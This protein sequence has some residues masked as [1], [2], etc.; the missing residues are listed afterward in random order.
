MVDSTRTRALVLAGGGA[1]GAYEVGV[2]HYIF[3]ELART[4]PV[5]PRFDIFAGTS[6]GAINGCFLAA[7]AH[8]DDYF[9][10]RLVEL[11]TELRVKRWLS[12]H[13]RELVQVARS[14]MGLGT[15]QWGRRRRPLSGGRLG[16]LLNTQALDDIVIK[17]LCDNRISENIA[18]GYLRAVTVSTTE[19]ATG[20]TVCFVEKEGELPE[21]SLDSRRIARKADLG[22]DH[23]LASA[24]IPF[25]FPAVS[26]DGS[27][28]CDGGVRQP[29]PLSPALRLGADRVLVVALRHRSPEVTQ[30]QLANLGAYPDALFLFGKLLNALLL[31]PVEY[32]LAVLERVNRIMRHGR[33]VYGPNF[34]QELNAVVEPTRGK[35]YR[36]IDDILIKPR[37]DI[38]RMA[39]AAGSRMSRSDWGFGPAAQ[40]LRRFVRAERGAEADLLSYILF[41]GKFTRQL[42]QLGYEDAKAQRDQ[43]VAFFSDEPF[44]D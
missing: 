3:G 19:I 31:D 28:Y 30:E 42:I 23:A 21:W 18:E 38:G 10:D 24:A 5:V 14:V 13:Y 9:I 34:E 17:E 35:P 29:T 36:I 11:W 15:V 2:L 43:L 27:F 16:G 32:D 39:H 1:R 8:H 20:R 22:P 4:G 41:E 6:V 12:I 7:H 40:V 37:A 25:L 44:P 26:V 33:Q